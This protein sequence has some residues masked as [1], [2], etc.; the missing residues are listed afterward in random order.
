MHINLEAEDHSNFKDEVLNSLDNQNP[1]STPQL[2]EE[3]ENVGGWKDNYIRN[4]LLPKMLHFL[5]KED[6]V[7]LDHEKRKGGNPTQ[8]WVKTVK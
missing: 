5:R 4:L 2:A 7:L 6:E 8:F 3:V 1:K